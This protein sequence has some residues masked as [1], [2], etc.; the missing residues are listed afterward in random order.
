MLKK[1]TC[2]LLAFLILLTSVGVTI[3]MHYC[4]MM[5]EAT[6]S[7]SGPESSCCGDEGE[8]SGCCENTAHTAKLK[9]DFTPSIQLKFATTHLVSLLP[10]PVYTDSSKPY[11]NQTKEFF[12]Y[13]DHSPPDYGISLTILYRSILI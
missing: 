11:P 13:H 10:I 3:Y 1:A 12:S 4:P 2:I 5:D 6:Y 9:E 7:I 8:A